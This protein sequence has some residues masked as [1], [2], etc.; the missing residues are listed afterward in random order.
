MIDRCPAATSLSTEIYLADVQA[1]R[2]S[3]S[4]LVLC[5]II[6]NHNYL[7]DSHHTS[8]TV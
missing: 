5:P 2:Y 6:I 8:S 1:E 3:R 7:A 4:L